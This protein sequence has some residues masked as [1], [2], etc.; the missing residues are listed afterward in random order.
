MLI[1]SL[2]LAIKGAIANHDYRSVISPTLDH[3]WILSIF[4]SCIMSQYRFYGL[5]IIP[6]SIT[7]VTKYSFEGHIFAGHKD[8]TRFKDVFANYKSTKRFIL[9]FGRGVRTILSSSRSGNFW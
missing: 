3:I 7:D 8:G 6:S 5:I 1:G 9:K 4:M 2:M